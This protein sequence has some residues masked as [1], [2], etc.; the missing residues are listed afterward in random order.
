MLNRSLWP[1]DRKHPFENVKIRKR[2]WDTLSKIDRLWILFLIQ[3]YC[4]IFNGNSIIHATWNT[5]LHH[6]L[7]LRI[8]WRRFVSE[9]YEWLQASLG[10]R[11]VEF[12]MCDI[13]NYCWSTSLDEFT[14]TC[15]RKTRKLSSKRRIVCSKRKAFPIDHCETKEYKPTHRWDSR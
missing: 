9:S 2:L 4:T 13:G 12:G 6:S 5:Q 8:V 14:V 1:Q 15:S 10:C 11:Y 3:K 7:K